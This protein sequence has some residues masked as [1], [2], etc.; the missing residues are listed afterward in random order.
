MEKEIGNGNSW[1][2][3][4]RWAQSYRGKTKVSCKIY[5]VN[6][7][8]FLE[9]GERGETGMVQMKIDTG[10]SEPKR[11][12]AQWTPFAARQETAQQLGFLYSLRKLLGT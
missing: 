2:L 5:C 6:T 11:Q 3:L 10:N 12:P 4:L 1:I 8:V 9:D 7:T